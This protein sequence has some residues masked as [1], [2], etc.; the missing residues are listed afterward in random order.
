VYVR[1]TNLG[2]DVVVRDAADNGEANQEDLSVGIAERS[3]TIILF[4]TCGRVWGWKAWLEHF[5]RRVCWRR[6][7]RGETFPFRTCSIPK[8]KFDGLFASSD[9]DYVVIAV[10]GRNKRWLESVNSV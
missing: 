7:R 5:L 6:A 8:T 10:N 2:Q 1:S 3:E 9:V 4:L